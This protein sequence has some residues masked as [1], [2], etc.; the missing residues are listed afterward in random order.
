MGDSSVSRRSQSARAPRGFRPKALT[1]R[2]QCSC[3]ET[4]C[5]RCGDILIAPE[6]SGY[7]A[8]GYAV[9]WWSCTNCDYQFETCVTF[10]RESHEPSSSSLAI[11]AEVIS[12]QLTSGTYRAKSAQGGVS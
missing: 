4:F 12:G 9:H 7:V 8:N 10:Q 2:N 11:R 5:A 6:W 1:A 3:S